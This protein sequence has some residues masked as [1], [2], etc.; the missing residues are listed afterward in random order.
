M[1]DTPPSPTRHN[2][3]PPNTSY[4]DLGWKAAAISVSDWISEV[5]IQLHMHKSTPRTTA[6]LPR[7]VL[8]VVQSPCRVERGLAEFLTVT[9]QRGDKI[10]S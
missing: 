2:I 4:Y 6:N 9:E 5:Q 7:F 10:S 8:L 3:A 1:L